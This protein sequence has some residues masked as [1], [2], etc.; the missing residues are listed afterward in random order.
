MPL[1]CIDLKLLGSFNEFL[2]ECKVPFILVC[3]GL[4]GQWLIDIK[5]FVA[6]SGQGCH[7]VIGAPEVPYAL[8]ALDAAN[9]I[10]SY[11]SFS[12]SEEIPRSGELCSKYTPMR[13][14][15]LEFSCTGKEYSKRGLSKLLRLVII[16][17]AIRHG[18]EAVVSSANN[19][20]AYILG[21]YFGFEVEDATAFM[22]E[23]CA[24]EFDPLVNARLLLDEDHLE[25]YYRTYKSMTN[26]DLVAL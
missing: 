22:R 17:Y 3:T 11:I 4:E 8:V 5:K 25:T 14:V 13:A 15:A 20:S 1:S 23:N 16:T 18:Y 26:C 12:A 10:A 24:F 6:A 19:V 7:Q 21:K 2:S 9:N